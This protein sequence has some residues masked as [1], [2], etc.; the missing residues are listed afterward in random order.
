[1]EKKKFRGFWIIFWAVIALIVILIASPFVKAM[2]NWNS[3]HKPWNYPSST[4]ICEEPY[5][6]L[7]V[8]ADG[9]AVCTTRQGDDAETCFV[10]YR[11]NNVCFIERM[12][13]GSYGAELARGDGD[14]SAEKFTV[15]FSPAVVIPGIS[16]EPV[17]ELVFL[18]Q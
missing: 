3:D 2:R 12:E 9:Q 1:M 13:G 7:N 14:Y 6:I 10:D 11:G 16:E 17:S 5:L 4:W 18:R 15:T 8:T